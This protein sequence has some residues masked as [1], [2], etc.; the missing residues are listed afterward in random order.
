MPLICAEFIII[1]NGWG[2][3][4]QDAQHH[5]FIDSFWWSKPAFP[6]NFCPNIAAVVI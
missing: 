3:D 4:D 5:S 6:P 2:Q 1:L